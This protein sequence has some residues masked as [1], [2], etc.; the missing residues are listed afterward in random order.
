MVINIHSLLFATI[1]WKCETT[2]F[3]YFHFLYIA[4]D[5]GLAPTD[6]VSLLIPRLVPFKTNTVLEKKA[7]QKK[8][9][10]KASADSS[11]YLELRTPVF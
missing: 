5:I 4:G 7:K 9:E 2:V 11:A 1:F 3:P 8:G 6:V 10:D